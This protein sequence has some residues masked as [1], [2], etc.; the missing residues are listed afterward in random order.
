MLKLWQEKDVESVAAGMFYFKLDDP[1]ILSGKSEVEAIQGEI[2]KTLKLKGLILKDKELLKALDENIENS[3]IL[4]CKIKKNGEFAATSK[5][6]IDK[7]QIDGL[8]SHAEKTIANIGEEIFQGNISIKPVK[9][10]D[11]EACTYCNYK[12]IC[13]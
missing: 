13:F 12:S 5:G 4:N 7:E 11:K 9:T 2:T 10:K 3:D 6:L 1:L 8:I